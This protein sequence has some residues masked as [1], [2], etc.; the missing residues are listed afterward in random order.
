MT[1]FVLAGPTGVGKTEVGLELARRLNLEIV[2]ADSRQVYRH[3]DIGTAKPG[4]EMRAACRFHM[5][6]VV[7]P[8]RTYSAAEYA[9]DAV[10]VMR[11]LVRERRQFIIVGGAGFYLRALF[12][13]L[14]TAPA[15]SPELR[16]RLAGMG[17]VAL[18]EHLR[19]LD[20]ERAAAL[21]PN[22]RQRV[23]RAIEICELAGKTF[24]ELARE[25]AAGT[26]FTPWYAVLNMD[27]DLLYRRIDLRFDAM[28][29]QGL[30][31]EVRLLR[32]RGFGRE[33]RV[34]DA[35]GYAELFDHLEGRLSL[36]AAIERAKARSREYA[37]RQ[38]TWFRALRQ[39]RWFDHRNP[40]ETLRVLE[41]VLAGLLVRTGLGQR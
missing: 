28:M 10:T 26:E 35:Y 4:P 14:F 13:P 27:R 6:D 21:H 16:Q 31:E 8:D 25:S 41:P 29:E 32:A 33:S 24:A 7:E 40:D 39:A 5:L 36:A 34:A 38:L 11:G 22:D 1:V 17:T 15:A 2:S 19:R 3:L 20:P 18:Y 12:Q 37:R 9:R 23:T 30:L